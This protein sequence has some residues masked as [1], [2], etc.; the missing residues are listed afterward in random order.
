MDA[1][2]PVT[3]G[4][5]NAALTS[6]LVGIHNEYLGRGPRG[7]YTFYHDNVVVTI[8]HDVITLAEKRLDAAGDGHAV[9]STRVLFQKAMRPE[10]TAA[11]QRL[12]GRRVIAFVSGNDL[13]A[14]VAVETF[15][16]DGPP[17]AGAV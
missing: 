15:I 17:G 1:S 4:E 8:M 11:V 12:T 7:A 6:A 10:F 2:S 13:D 5:L 3:G 9:S 16:L 14:D